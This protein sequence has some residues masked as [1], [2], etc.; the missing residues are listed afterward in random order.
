M[1]S[2][3]EFYSKLRKNN[4]VK[5]VEGKKCP[6]CGTQLIIRNGVYGSFMACPGYPKCKHIENLPKEV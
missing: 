4:S 5:I 2:F 6:N 1:Q 3:E